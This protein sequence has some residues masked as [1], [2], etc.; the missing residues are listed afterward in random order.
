MTSL[1]Q[2]LNDEIKRRGYVPYEDCLRL[3][4][5]EGYRPS[6]MERRLRKSESPDIEPVMKKS[7]RGT[8]YVAGYKYLYPPMYTVNLAP[9]VNKSQHAGMII[10][11]PPPVEAVNNQSL[12]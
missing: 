8:E 9:I 10:Q 4:L 12:F 6:N 11:V 1:R 3:T 5:E 7:K 2:Q